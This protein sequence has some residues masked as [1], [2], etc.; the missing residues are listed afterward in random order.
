M[1][2]KKWPGV[3]LPDIPG[4]KKDVQAIRK[5]KSGVCGDGGE[6][7][8]EDEISELRNSGI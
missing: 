5:D 1:D 8:Y 3:V 2:A 6:R 4:A 7:I